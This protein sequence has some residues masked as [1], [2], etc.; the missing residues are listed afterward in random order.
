MPI[1]RISGNLGQVTLK[2]EAASRQAGDRVVQGVT[3]KIVSEIARRNH[4][5]TGRMVGNWNVGLNAPDNSYDEKRLDPTGSGMRSRNLPVTARAK[6]GD[7]V[8]ITNSTPYAGYEEF[9]TSKRAGHPVIRSIAAEIPL[10]VREVVA[11][12]RTAG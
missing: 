4:V 10:Y 6:L 7:T 11:R 2:F 5:I 3:A 1:L 9:G 8:Y 12:A